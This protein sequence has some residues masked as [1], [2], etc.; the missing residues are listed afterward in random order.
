MDEIKRKQYSDLIELSIVLAFLFMIITIYVP[1]A[2]WVEEVTAAEGARFNIQ[3]V[4]DVEYFY[5]ILTDGYEENGLWAMNVVNAV[6]DSVMADSTYLGERNFE[7]AGESV[8][9]II[10]EGYDVE[11]DTTFGI[12]KT[13]RDTLIDTIHTVVTYS[14]EMFRNDT[15]F[16][17]T[18]DLPTVMIEEGFIANLGFETKQRSEVVSY[19]D[20]YMPDSSNFYCPLTGEI[21]VVRLKEEGEVLRVASPIEGVYSEGR[22]LLFSFKT[23]SHGYIEDGSRSWDQ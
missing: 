6:R 11:F 16:V 9:V 21:I 18:E 14:E 13:R 23:R 8:N 10:P 19:Y 12:L 17:S 1:S 3:T 7:L 4:H 20:S 22:Y 2:I 5:K 15:G